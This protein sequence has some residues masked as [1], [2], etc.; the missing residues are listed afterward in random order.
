VI[1]SA[2]FG[3]RVREGR[4]RRGLS[5]EALG[6]LTGLHRTAIYKLEKG[7]TAPRLASI[8]RLARGLQVPPRELIEDDDESP[9]SETDDVPLLR[10]PW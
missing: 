9:P 7:G 8:R 2:A 4:E 6:R 5:Q 10:A 3:R 1:A